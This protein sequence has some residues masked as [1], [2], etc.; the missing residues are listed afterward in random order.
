M[1]NQ[2][3][4]FKGSCVELP[5]KFITE[6]VDRSIPISYRTFRK[7]VSGKDLREMFTVYDWGV[8][9]GLHIQDDWAVSFYRSRYKKKFYYFVQ[10]SG[11]EFIW[12]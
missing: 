5:G 3:L 6:I 10:W 8:K 1:K 9:G 2:K 11:I 12:H 7:Y 4:N